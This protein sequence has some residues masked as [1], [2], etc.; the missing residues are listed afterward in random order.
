MPIVDEDAIQDAIHAWNRREYPSIRQTAAAYRVDR[1]TLGRRLKGGNTRQ[2][3]KETQR[4]LSSAQED[5]L[6]RWIVDLDVAGA[7]PNFSQV[8]E[9]AGLISASSGG[10]PTVGENWI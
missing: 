7:A 8:R 10:P 5:L 3:G 9:F 4:L 1:K 2:Q 6:I